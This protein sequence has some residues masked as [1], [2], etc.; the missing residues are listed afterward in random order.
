MKR[1]VL[2]G[3]IWAILLTACTQGP[4]APARYTAWIA[5][6]DH[7]LVT[8]KLFN[9]VALE[10]RYRP[11]PQIALQELGDDLDQ[12]GLEKVVR[13]RSGAHYFDLRFHAVHGGEVLA[14]SA[15]S[16]D[17]FY[18]RLYHFTTEVE[19]DLL[20]VAGT[21]TIPCALAHFERTYG[22][23]PY[24]DLVISFIDDAATTERDDLQFIYDDR[25]FGLGRVSFTIRR[26]DIEA[27]PELKLS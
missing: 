27:I 19:N 23:V 7:G 20:L 26:K 24:N 9:D 22:A 21:D 16:Q 17:D 5:D 8:R 2:I 14:A 6:P 1:G 25:V 13:E 15:A 18:H 3:M 4:L 11:L 10:L 12:D